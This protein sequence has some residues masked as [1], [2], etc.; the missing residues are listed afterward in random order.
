MHLSQQLDRF[1][2]SKKSMDSV[3]N[4][5]IKIKDLEFI[6]VVPKLLPIK[7]PTWVSGIGKNNYFYVPEEAIVEKL[8][9]V[10][11]WQKVDW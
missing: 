11:D 3:R 9:G 7:M 4:L 6:N 5:P 2:D 10:M 1:W 8:D